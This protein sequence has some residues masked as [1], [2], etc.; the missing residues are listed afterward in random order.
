MTVCKS[1]LPNRRVCADGFFQL[2]ACHPTPCHGC[3]RLSERPLPYCLR[4]DLPAHWLR[5][6]GSPAFYPPL[7]PQP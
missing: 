6:D 7:E 3:G 1:Y 5:D 2:P 4:E